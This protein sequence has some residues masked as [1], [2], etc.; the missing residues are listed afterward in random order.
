MDKTKFT[1]IFNRAFR[2]GANDRAGGGLSLSGETQPP[3]Q[4]PSPPADCVVS[5]GQAA[6]TEGYTMG[7]RLGASDADLASVDVPGAHGMIS[8]M[9]EQMLEMFGVFKDEN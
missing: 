9:S 1:E 3:T 6:W 2:L 7:Y 8:G 5:S 4:I